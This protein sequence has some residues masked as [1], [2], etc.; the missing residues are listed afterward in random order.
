[1]VTRLRAAEPCCRARS[2]ATAMEPLILAALRALTNSRR[3]SQFAIAPPDTIVANRIESARPI[4][5]D[6]LRR[7]W[8]SQSCLVRS[9]FGR[10]ER[11][12]T[13]VHPFHFCFL[14]TQLLMHGLD[15]VGPHL[16]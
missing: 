3:G 2:E 1:M 6:S 5:E 10:S 15:V 4:L 14:T 16:P 9:G 8:S 13:S 7:R 11:L 12:A